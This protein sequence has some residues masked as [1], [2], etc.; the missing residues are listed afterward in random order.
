MNK[1]EKLAVGLLVAVLIGWSF[2]GQRFAPERPIPMDVEPGIASEDGAVAD[3]IAPGEVVPATNAVVER[4][5]IA[6][7]VEVADP[8]EPLPDP[9]V[10][11]LTNEVFGVDFTSHGGGIAGVALVQYAASLEM[12]NAALELAFD[13]VPALRHDGLPGFAETTIFAMEPLVDGRSIRMRASSDTVQLTRTVTLGEGYELAVQDVLEN[14]TTNAITLAGR[15]LQT[16]EM[17]LQEASPGMRGM[18]YLGVDYLSTEE[19]K[20]Q[21]T[22]KEIKGYFGVPGGCGTPDLR[23]VPMR[24]QE[25]LPISS[26]WLA[27]KNKFF[28][29]ILDP[30]CGIEEIMV[31][32]ARRDDDSFVV[33]GVRA[34]ALLPS[35]TLEPGQTNENE[36]RYYA[37]PKKYTLLRRAGD[38]RAGIMEF[39]FF[40]WICQVL[41][42]LLNAIEYVIPGGY[43]VAVILLTIIVKLVFWPVTHKGTESMKRMQ[44]LQPELKKLREK[45]KKDPKKLQEKQMLLYREHKVNPLA[46]CLPMVIQIPVFIG[47]FTVLRSAVELRYARFLW[48]ADLSEPEGLLAG[49]LPFPAG[50]LNILPLFMTATMVLQQR[51]TPSAGDPQQ[52]K[53][54]AFMPVMMLFIFYNMPSGLVLY[55]SVSQLLSILQLALQNRGG[56]KPVLKTA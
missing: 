21:H 45:Y 29:Q 24:V 31:D 20:V 16:G 3:S 56:A 37:G 10:I 53:M 49:V 25:I 27:V 52:Q 47:L 28:T 54:M 18:S 51:L 55:W 38:Q 14:V 39:G 17:I 36:I 44:A 34:S 7:T 19:E 32:A 8:T 40:K 35:L 9:V 41:L 12:R 4:V 11:T 5:D 50:G 46:G 13:E 30:A 15:R 6:E 33:N 43:G 26:S 2:L 23:N 22:G 48:I 42:P 1:V